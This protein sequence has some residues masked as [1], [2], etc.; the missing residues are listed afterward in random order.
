MSSVLTI[1][2]LFEGMVSLKGINAGQIKG[3]N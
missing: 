3:S 2:K 1:G